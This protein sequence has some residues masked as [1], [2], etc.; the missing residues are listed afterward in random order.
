MNEEIDTINQTLPTVDAGY[1]DE[2]DTR[3]YSSREKAV[4]IRSWIRSVL[5]KIIE[6]KAEHRRL[7]DEDVSPTLQ[8]FV[9]RDIVMNS[10]L[11]F[12]ELPSNSFE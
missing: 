11:P 3:E 1:Y 8:R 7:L 4:A 9:P 10:V 5:D 12:L 6:Y 2:D